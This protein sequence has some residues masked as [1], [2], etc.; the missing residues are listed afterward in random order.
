M[1]MIAA[2][3]SRATLTRC[4]RVYDGLVIRWKARTRLIWLA[5]LARVKALPAD[6]RQ[7]VEAEKA[8]WID[9]EAFPQLVDVFQNFEDA[10]NA[11]LADGE[12]HLGRIVRIS[13]MPPD[14]VAAFR[15]LYLTSDAPAS[16]IL[17]VIPVLARH[18][19][20]DHRAVLRINLSGEKALQWATRP[21]AA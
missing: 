17:A 7:F 5:T 21:D 3:Q 6:R 1:A 9:C 19:A 11:A 18:C 12:Y 2:A 10:R 4:E 8:W 14:I 16:V 15:D 20:G 13:R